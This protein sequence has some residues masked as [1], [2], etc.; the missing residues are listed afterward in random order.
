MK[1]VTTISL[2][3]AL[4]LLISACNFPF[5][6]TQSAVADSVA[7][8]VAALEAEKAAEQVVPTLAPLPTQ[9]PT[10]TASPKSNDR[11]YP[12]DRD[13]YRCAPDDQQCVRCDSNSQD[14]CDRCQSGDR[15]CYRYDDQSW[16]N[17]W[18]SNKGGWNDGDHRGRREC[19]YATFLGETVKD[20]TS[21]TAGDAFTK[22]WTL[23]NDGTCDWN[24]DYKLVFKSGNQMGG[25][26]EI[27][28]SGTISPGEQIILSVNLTAPAS[29]GT[30]LGYWQ[31][32]TDDDSN[33]GTALSVKIKVE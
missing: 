30:Y 27:P 5:V 24:E 18:G 10:E 31:L 11:C 6:D 17:Y 14:S 19:L 7:Q 9:V 3:V 1:R 23:R 29:A 32:Q 25:V 12:G 21:F 2:L 20:N 15:D 28:F 26:D 13:C 4:A 16:S 8:T 22:T 33:F